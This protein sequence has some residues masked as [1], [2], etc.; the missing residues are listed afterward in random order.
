[1]YYQSYEEMFEYL[2]RNVPEDID[3]REGSLLNIVL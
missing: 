3:M 1:M 2:K